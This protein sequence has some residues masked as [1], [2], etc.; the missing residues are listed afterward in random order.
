MSLARAGGHCG[1]GRG[2]LEERG[3][4][5]LRISRCWVQQLVRRYEAEGEAAFVAALAPAAVQPARDLAGARGRDRRLRKD[6]A[7]QGLDAGAETIAP[8][9]GATG[10]H[11]AA[12]DLDD[13]ADPDP[14]R[15]RHPA[16]AVSGRRS[17]GTG[18]QADQPNERWQ[19][20]ITHWQLADG[21]GVEILNIIDDH[22]RLDLASDARPDHH[23]PR[24]R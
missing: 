21:T 12:V 2:P 1:H 10:P 6:L 7:E 4:P 24:R 11:P 8:I 14:P 15:V 9:C 16:A 18:S 22:S 17:P 23:R 19:A 13:L 5:R 20:D 3:R